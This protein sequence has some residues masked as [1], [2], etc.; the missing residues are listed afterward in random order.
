MR[1]SA[2]NNVGIGTTSPVGKLDV[3]GALN[4][5]SVAATNAVTI[6]QFHAVNIPTNSIVASSA[7]GTNWTYCVI[8]GLPRII[9]TNYAAAGKFLKCVGETV[10]EFP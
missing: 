6:W 1:F 8:G 5:T 4:A 7:S 2:N 9:A 10:S 3:N